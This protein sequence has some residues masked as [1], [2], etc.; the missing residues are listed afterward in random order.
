[1]KAI[2]L[3]RVSTEEQKEAGNSLPA[4]TERLKRYCERKDF[5]IVESFSFDESAYKQK[6]DE[7]DK[8]LDVV[9]THIKKERVAVCFDKVDRLS[10]SVFDK[11]V[12]ELYELA[13]QDTIE[14]HFVS[15]GQV[16]NSQISAVEKFQFGMSLGL[17][18]YYSD[19]IGDNVKRAFELKRRNG[20]WT[21]SIPFGYE[22]VARDPIKRTRSDI[23]R[24]SEHASVVVELFKRFAS[25]EISGNALAEDLEH[26]GVRNRNGGRISASNV[27]TILA[28]PFYYGEAYSKKYDERWQHRYEPL[29]TKDLWQKAQDVKKTRS[30]NKIKTNKNR[31]YLFAGLF[32]CAKCG[33][34]MTPELKKGRYV[35]Y[36]CTNSKGVCKREYTREEELLKP[37]QEALLKLEI[38]DEEAKQVAAFIKQSHA[39]Q[40]R[41]HTT[42]ITRLRGEYDALQA[43]KGR[44]LDLRI[45]GEI[46]EETYAKKLDQ[47]DRRQQEVNIALEELTNADTNYHATAQTVLSLARRAADIF[48]S[49]EIPEKRQL[50]S[51][52]I[53]NPRVNGKKLEFE[54]QKPFDLIL[55]RSQYTTLLTWVDSFRTWDW[56]KEIKLS[57]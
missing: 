50:L 11:R 44:L 12:A 27:Y 4:Q 38:T 36:S 53:Q 51:F 15:D 46:D 30:R 14:L 43:K 47:F 54:L 29:I 49:S 10:R 32:T 26:R 33:C 41:Y 8:L 37:I 23:I 40:S 28:N 52:L 3:A 6:R 18:K 55:K 1:M 17:A 5:E 34:A 31:E 2:I 25:G 45:E 56:D 57:F 16:I 20:E 42:Q 9:K 19:A 13:L 21:G 48:E 7:F 22:P 39:D 24:H 35:Y